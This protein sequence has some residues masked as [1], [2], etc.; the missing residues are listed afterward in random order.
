MRARAGMKH[1]SIYISHAVYLNYNGV[2]L[3]LNVVK[4]EVK[5][6]S[7]TFILEISSNVCKEAIMTAAVV[8]LLPGN[9]EDLKL[10]S[11]SIN[12]GCTA[13]AVG[14]KHTP[15]SRLIML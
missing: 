13:C 11:V 5:G 14:I 7:F 15:T 8:F 3:S 12:T 4:S 2:Y 9:P 1:P 6:C 10:H